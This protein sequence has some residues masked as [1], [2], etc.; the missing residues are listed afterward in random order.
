MEF[1]IPVITS[2]YTCIYKAGL[3]PKI[4]A[5]DLSLKNALLRA[6]VKIYKR[7]S[8][9]VVPK[10][11]LRIIFSFWTFFFYISSFYGDRHVLYTIMLNGLF[12]NSDSF[13]NFIEFSSVW[14]GYQLSR[15]YCVRKEIIF[16]IWFRIIDQESNSGC[17]SKRDRFTYFICSI[18]WFCMKWFIFNCNIIKFNCSIALGMVEMVMFA[19]NDALL[20]VIIT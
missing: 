10:N 5:S 1:L 18:R 7:M 4:H 16:H 12:V 15:S 13:I 20:S 19:A 9:E 6:Y 17:Q 3:D 14:S 11:L 2:K 8:L